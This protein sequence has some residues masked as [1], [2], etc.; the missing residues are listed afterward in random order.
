MLFV[1][2]VMAVVAVSN[3]C[4][5]AGSVEP[6]CAISDVISFTDDAMIEPSLTIAVFNAATAAV[7]AATSAASVCDMAMSLCC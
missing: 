5:T 4:S 2:L 7:R 1:A 6:C 3:C